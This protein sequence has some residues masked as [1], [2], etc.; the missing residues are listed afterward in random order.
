MFPLFFIGGW[1]GKFLDELFKKELDIKSLVSS[2]VIENKFE[3]SNEAL[4]FIGSYESFSNKPY[5]VKGENFYT[6]GYGSTRIFSNDGSKSRPVLASDYVTQDQALFH[7]KMYYAQ[8]NSVQKQIDKIIVQ[9]GVKLH[10]RFYDMLLQFSY[11]SGSFHKNS[12]F[13]NQ[14]ITMLKRANGSSDLKMIGEL[15]RDTWIA[16]LKRYANYTAFGLGWSRRA[17]AGGQYVQ[18][19]N[20]SKLNAERTI[21]KP[22]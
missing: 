7:K 11:A 14:Y 5:K 21:K 22:Y 4:L 1:F 8:P 19:L 18:G 3:I 16:Y 6:I 2:S 13:V 17:Y 10:P 20:Y 9:N 15:L 12:G